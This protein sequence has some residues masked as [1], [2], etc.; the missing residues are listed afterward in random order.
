MPL[1]RGLTGAGFW[2]EGQAHRRSLNFARGWDQGWGKGG[3]G[4]MHAGMQNSS[5]LPCGPASVL[6]GNLGHEKGRAQ[7]WQSSGNLPN[8]PKNTEDSQGP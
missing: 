7:R 6:G 8:H 3:R 2:F 4:Q 5:D 1:G